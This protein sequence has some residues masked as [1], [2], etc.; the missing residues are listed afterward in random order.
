M[1]DV[2]DSYPVKLT[3]YATLNKISDEPAFA[4]WTN[5][6]LKKKGIIISIIKSKFFK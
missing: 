4:W 2:K 6:T 1:K 3:E 5:Y